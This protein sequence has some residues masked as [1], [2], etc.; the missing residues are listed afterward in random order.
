MNLPEFA[1]RRP[2]TVFMLFGAVLIFGLLALVRLPV[3]LMPSFEMPMVSVITL[4][5]GAGS[6]DIETNVTEIMEDALSAISGV[7]HVDSV[8]QTGIS[9]VMVQFE[10]GTDLTEASSDIRDIIDMLGTMLPND[11]EP[12]MLMK[13]SS[14]NIPILM[15]GVTAEESFESLRH[16]VRD[17][18]AE[19]LK[20]VPGVAGVE[21]M[22]GPEREIQVRVDPGRLESLGIPME[23]IVQ[24]LAAENLD[25]PAGNVKLGWTE[26]AVRV[27]GS[28]EAVDELE[29]IV[30]GQ[31][32]GRLIHLR[33]IA[34]VQDDFAE[35]RMKARCDQV[36]GVVFFVSKQ[37]GTN[38][39]TVSKAALDRLEELKAELPPD[40]EMFTFFDTSDFI[41]K[42]LRNLRQA[43][44]FGALGVVVVVLLFLRRLRSTV[45]I[46]LTIPAAL[47]ASLFVMYVSGYTI[48]MVSL[49]SLA[50]AIGMVVDSAVVTL[51]NVTRHVE[52]GERV[53]EAS[54]F[55]PAEIGQALSASTLTT[56]VVFLP[57]L[58]ITNITGILFK[59]MAL[60]VIVSIAMSLFAALT[61]TPAL[62]STLMR[63]SF[64]GDGEKRKKSGFFEWGERVFIRLEERYSA[65]LES[66]LR[67]KRRTILIAVGIFVVSMAMGGLVKTE[68]FPHPDSGEIEMTVELAPGTNLERTME[69]LGEV[70]D[71][72]EREVPERDYMWTYA[73]ETGSGWAIIQG[74]KEGTHVGRAGVQ[75]VDKELRSRTSDE[76]ADEIRRFTKTVPAIVRLNIRTGSSISQ[77]MGMGGAPISI[78]VKGENMEDL[79][80]TSIAIREAVRSVEGTVDVELDLGDP[81]PEFHVVI[82]RERAAALGLNTYGIASALRSNI[83]GVEA[84]KLRQGGDQWDVIV[85]AEENER[86]TVEDILALPIPS[87]TGE[88][89]RLSSV[90][91]VETGVGPTE[92]RR[93]DQER[94]VRVNGRIL[95]RALG[96]VAADVRA[97]LA[98]LDVPQGITVDYGG[99]VEQ[100]QESFADLGVLLLLSIVL[101]YMVMAS[102]FENLRDPFVVMF[103]IPFAFVGVIWAFLITNTTLSMTSFLGLIMLMGIVV[104]NAIVLVDYT[105]IM[106]KRGMGLEE[107]VLTAGSRRLRPVLMTAFTTIFGM[108]PLALM[109]ATGSEM[110]R[111]LGVAMVGGLLV[112][113]LV[114][115]ILVPTLYTIFEAR[116]NRKARV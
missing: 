95:N 92:I 32:M 108:L 18:I 66:A 80:A 36:P 116:L 69:V 63:R 42:A 50:I 37:S 12:P 75:L 41:G 87:M 78:Q 6:E 19:P 113:T 39:V 59:Q 11:I 94:I 60:V 74:E 73:G 25:I 43:L 72:I 81:K 34:D 79:E 102:Q 54:M 8:S 112:S 61:L 48:N 93:R 15:F 38:S 114:T 2:I 28:F 96:E 106:R 58:F 90:A 27:P 51:E 64:D 33:D 22:G 14:T 3:D 98:D 97:A 110:W 83:Y 105:N 111:P 99:D 71:F 46:G 21:V 101:V 76:V 67:H 16:I 7:E 52:S 109:R 23:Q 17:D 4:Y 31:S 89:V 103:S 82:D 107:A 115:L 88:M 35:Q 91:N 40:L 1:V 84:T 86:S 62:S 30:V 56:I 65:L 49:M 24:V 104:N 57:M 70:E 45:V 53:K 85:R 13:M 77:F 68:F 5:P 44:I 10:W 20:A 9:A 29:G 100:Q 47:A 26:Y 55:A